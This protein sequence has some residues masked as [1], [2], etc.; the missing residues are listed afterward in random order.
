MR[1]ILV[2]DD[3]E[4]IRKTIR[5]IL[6]DKAEGLFAGDLLEASYLFINH[7][8]KINTVLVDGSVKAGGLEELENAPLPAAEWIRR[9]KRLCIGLGIR[10]AVELVAFSTNPDSLKQLTD[11]GC[12]WEFLKGQDS[13]LE[14]ER[15]LGV[16]P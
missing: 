6:G 16:A 15:L 2:V 1:T 3:H 13:L 5:E 11:A 8:E 9:L 7:F 10:H 12:N 4:E 14:L